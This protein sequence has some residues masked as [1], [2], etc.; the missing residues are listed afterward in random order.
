MDTN[1]IRSNEQLS[2]YIEENGNP[3]FVFFYGG[4]YSQ[5]YNSP[6]TVDGKKFLTAEHWMM[7]KKAETFKDDDIV[8]KIFTV[9]HPAEVKKLGRLVK[10]FDAD[11]WAEVAFEYV[12]QGNVHKF[13]QNPE[14]RKLLEKNDG[15][16]LVEASPTDRIWGIGVSEW[17]AK[18]AI[19]VKEWKGTNLLGYAIME[20]RARLKGNNQNEK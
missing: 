13:S 17:D 20:A 19:P 11:K 16:V 14:I 8:K 9:E 10:N 7:F 5:W 1:Y 3:L 4:V 2:K 6:F 12:V 15:R 18:N